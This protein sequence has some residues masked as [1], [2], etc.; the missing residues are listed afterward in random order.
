MATY[1]CWAKMKEQRKNIIK[2]LFLLVVFSLNTIV[3]FACSI[4]INMGYNSRHHQHDSINA[5]IK[6]HSHKSG[7]K[8]SHG[9]S[10]KHIHQHKHTATT[11]TANHS[12]NDCCA[13]D[14]TKFIQLDKSIVKTNLNLQVPS[15]LLA[16]ASTFIQLSLQETNLATNSKLQPVRRSCSIYDTDIRI[17]I[18]SFQIWFDL[19]LPSLW[20]SY[21]IN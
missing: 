21:A 7:H 11:G 19:M 8:H 2:A 15:F 5:P 12:Q 18:Q 20:H 4:G 9:A 16:F 3:G 10:Q 17:A 6:S 1:L 14:V 13:N